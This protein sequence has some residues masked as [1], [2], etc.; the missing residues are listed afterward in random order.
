MEIRKC[1]NCG[2]LIRKRNKIYCSDKCGRLY[3]KIRREDCSETV[4]TSKPEQREQ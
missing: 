3:R 2:K 1:P 4:S